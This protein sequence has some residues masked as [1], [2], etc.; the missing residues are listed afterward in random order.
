MNKNYIVV[1]GCLESRGL[2]NNNPLNIKKNPANHWLGKIIKG[3]D[4]LFEQFTIME[5][6]VRAGL[7]LIFRN[8]L[9]KPIESLIC[10]WAP[11]CEN[12]TSM[13]VKFLLDELG[14]SHSHIIEKEDI[15]PLFCAMARY[16]S[17]LQFDI[18]YVYSVYSKYLM[19]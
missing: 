11:A 13:Y 5:Y 3:T 6:G 7:K 18:D 2:Y 1:S 12:N 8:G 9:C 4:P 15:V 16:E 14:W 19:S 17:N 10:L